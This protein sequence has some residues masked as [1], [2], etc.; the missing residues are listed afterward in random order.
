M[1]AGRLPEFSG[2][3]LTSQGPHASK[4]ILSDIECGHQAT[5]ALCNVTHVRLDGEPVQIRP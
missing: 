3:V 4:L 2:N 5:T 1:G